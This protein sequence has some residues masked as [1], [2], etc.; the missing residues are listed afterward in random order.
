[1]KYEKPHVV[2]VAS[3]AAA[4]QA[5]TKNSQFS[6]DMKEEYTLPAY[7]ADE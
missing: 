1:M 2:V 5:H 3:A 7:E 4:I 6:P